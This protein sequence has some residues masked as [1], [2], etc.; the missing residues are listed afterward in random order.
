MSGSNYL[1]ITKPTTWERLVKDPN[2]FWPV[3]ARN[4]RTLSGLEKGNE[5]IIYLTQKSVI[6]GI[7][8]VTEELKGT[9]KPFIIAG[10]IYEYYLTMNYKFILDKNHLIPMKSVLNELDITKGLK[11]W[12][13]GFQRSNRRLSDSDFRLLKEK[14]INNFEKQSTEGTTD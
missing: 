4:S 1:F 8:E 11:N 12:G 5:I 3:N 6:A 9:N 14:I 10:D 2:K 7:A 13:A